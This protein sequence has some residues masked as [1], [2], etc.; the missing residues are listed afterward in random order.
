[1][2]NIIEQ[3]RKMNKRNVVCVHQALANLC[4]LHIAYARFAI[5]EQRMQSNAKPSKFKPNWPLTVV[6]AAQ[7]AINTLAY[8]AT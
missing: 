4:N 7:S 2:F 5:R 3:K 8:Q 6:N 1:L